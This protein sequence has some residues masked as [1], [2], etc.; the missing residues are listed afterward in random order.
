MEIY[1]LSVPL[2]RHRT[3][4]PRPRNSLQPSADLGVA[5]PAYGGHQEAVIPNDHQLFSAALPRNPR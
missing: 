5:E 2:A 1:L 4:A 3:I